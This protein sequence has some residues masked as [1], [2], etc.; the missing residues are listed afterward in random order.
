MLPAA[1]LEPGSLSEL[2]GGPYPGARPFQYIL[3]Q[4]SLSWNKSKLNFMNQDWN[5][6]PSV[7]NLL[8]AVTFIEVLKQLA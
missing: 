5:D 7:L 4:W 1:P 2:M 3:S 8:I 6:V